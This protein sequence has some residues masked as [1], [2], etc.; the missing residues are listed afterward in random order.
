MSKKN[1][2]SWI[3]FALCFG[4]TAC[5]N[6]NHSTEPDLK[7]PINL[8]SPNSYQGSLVA[9]QLMTV[10]FEQKEYRLQ[11]L[12][13]ITPEQITLVGLSSFSLPMFNI[14]WDGFNLKSQSNLPESA[15][16]LSA[17][18][19]MEDIMFALWPQSSLQPLLS[20]KEWQ[21][22]VSNQARSFSDSDQNLIMTIDYKNH[23]QV[24]GTINVSYHDIGVEYQLKTLQWD[25]TYE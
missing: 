18:R 3:V 11:M 9:Q 14:S 16:V 5:V 6:S 8:L 4:L 25:A 23:H 22:E 19:M 24:N 13:E 21:V 12:L 15:E 10:E 2:V 17:E 20:T 7:K 1:I